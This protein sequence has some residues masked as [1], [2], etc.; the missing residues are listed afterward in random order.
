[1]NLYDNF[2]LPL[3]QVRRDSSCERVI[4]SLIN[5]QRVECSCRPDGLGKNCEHQDDG[6]TTCFAKQHLCTGN[7]C[8]GSPQCGFLFVCAVELVNVLTP[9]SK[10]SMSFNPENSFLTM[11]IVLKLFKSCTNICNDL[12]TE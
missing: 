9:N 7:I 11:R 10:N 1:M 6:V 12:N 3:P 5:K 2:M 4:R 8:L